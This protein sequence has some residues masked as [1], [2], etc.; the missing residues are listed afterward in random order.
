MDLGRIGIWTG[1]LDQHPA[2]RAQDA[3]AEVEALGYGALWFP[4]AMGREAFTNAFGVNDDQAWQATRQATA[5]LLADRLAELPA[6]RGRPASSRARG[7]PPPRASA[8]ARS[9]CTT[10]P[11]T[12]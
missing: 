4:E 6:G 2:A 10:G 7:T 9:I 12:G 5:S 1:V 11:R 8:R 3:A